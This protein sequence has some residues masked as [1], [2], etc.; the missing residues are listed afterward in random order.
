MQSDDKPINGQHNPNRP[1]FF[2]LIDQTPPPAV[3]D[4]EDTPGTPHF[5]RLRAA[6]GTSWKKDG[7]L[8]GRW[9]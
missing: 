9:E 8:H 3:T 4:L 6:W 1:S 7:L 5:A 2:D